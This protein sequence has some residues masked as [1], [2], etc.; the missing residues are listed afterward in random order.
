L[1]SNPEMT[2]SHRWC[3]NNCHRLIT[4]HRVIYFIL[5]QKPILHTIVSYNDSVVKV[6]NAASSFW[7]AF[8]KSDQSYYKAGA[9]VENSYVVGNRYGSCPMNSVVKGHC[10]FK[11]GRKNAFLQHWMDWSMCCTFKQRWCCSARFN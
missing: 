6:Y 7:S 1:P 3:S 9:V 5:D 4:L 11:V 8:W 10:D 2:F